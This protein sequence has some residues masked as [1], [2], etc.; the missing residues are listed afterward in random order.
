MLEATR[1][2]KFYGAFAAVRDVSFTVEPGQILG[3]LGPNGSG[4]STTVKMLVGLIEP[5]GGRVTFNARDI[6]EDV[7]AYKQRI[8]YVPEEAHLYSYLTG[9]DYLRLVGR[10]RGLDEARL[11]EKIERFLRLWGIY[12]DRYAPIAAY[13][14]GMRQKVLL[15]AALLHD[16]DIIV[17]DEPDSGLDVASTIVLRKVVHGLAQA[18]KIV[19]FSSHVLEAVE[20]M[21]STVVILDRGRVVAHD[22]VT[23]LRELMALSSLEQVFAKLVVDEDLDSVSGAMLEA[24]RL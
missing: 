24:M 23:R 19:V 2:S 5:T 22:A 16:P 4:K 14:K 20:K 10:L 17:L 9:P 15:S 6:H 12:D 7:T 13:S 3:Y 1:L 11:D 8:G 21:C 18:G